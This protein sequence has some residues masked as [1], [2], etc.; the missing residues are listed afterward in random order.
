ME[1]GFD[2]SNGFSMIF[3]L[4]I[5]ENPF[6]PSNPCSINSAFVSVVP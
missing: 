3:F 6:D 1:H 4:L 5:R 2:G